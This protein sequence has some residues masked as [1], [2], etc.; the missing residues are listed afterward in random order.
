MT[1]RVARPQDLPLRTS[2]LNEL[3][4][5]ESSHLP[6]VPYAPGGL[7]RELPPPPVGRKGWPWT[8][9]SPSDAIDES[10]RGKPVPRLT[11]VTPSY[12]QG[13]FLEETIRSVLL[14]NHPNLEYLVM[15]GGSTDESAQVIERYKP[16]LSL[17]RSAR[18]RGQAH[19]INLGLAPASGELLGWINSDDFYL[20]GAFAHLSREAVRDHGADLFHGDG[21]IV[22]EHGGFPRYSL[23]QFVRGRFRHFGGLLLSHATFW[24]A[25]IHEPLWERLNCSMDAELWHRLL[26]GRKCHYIPVP[27]GVIREH[28]ATKT[29][30]SK[31]IEAWRSDDLAIWALHGHPPRAR[32]LPRI[33]YILT[34]RLA[35]F[36][37]AR[38]ACRE[39][40]AVL[41]RCGWQSP[42]ALPYE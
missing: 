38:L 8:V 28:A 20:P 15:D 31:H 6:K 5:A 22:D 35:G 27:L 17:S 29:H 41:D 19:A 37:R 30:N 36:V 9:E 3:G 1:P 25:R 10:T 7:L 11:V 39:R 32:S 12:N 42:A 2:H 26:P 16:W 13:R 24:R 14:Q 4:L 18:D 40:R 21:L 23:A 33:E 34:Q